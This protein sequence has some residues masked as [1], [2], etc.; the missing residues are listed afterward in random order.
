MVDSNKGNSGPSYCNVNVYC[1]SILPRGLVYN[2]T[3]DDNYCWATELIVNFTGSRH[4]GTKDAAFKIHIALTIPLAC[5][6]VGYLW[7]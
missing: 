2:C 6:F 3:R 1:N 7:W 4:Q 5:S